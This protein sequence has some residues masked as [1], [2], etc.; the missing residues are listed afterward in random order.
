MFLGAALAWMAFIGIILLAIR[1]LMGAATS[2]VNSG[3]KLGSALHPPPPPPT[4]VV[5]EF[6]K[7]TSEAPTPAVDRTMLP[8][9]TFGKK[10]TAEKMVESV[11]E[12]HPELEPALKE[13]KSGW[14][15]EINDIDE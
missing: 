8:G 1:L 10:S 14:G 2:V 4:T 7:S 6:L 9:M 5:K 3:R 15:I 13:T 11:A 12:Q